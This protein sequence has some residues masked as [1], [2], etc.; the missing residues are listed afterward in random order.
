MIEQNIVC[1]A[2]DWFEDPTSNNHVM[3][4]LARDNQVLW[5][6]SIS[7]RTPDFKS[8]KDIAKIGRKLRSFVRGPTRVEE[9]LA[10]YTPVVLP[11]PHSSAAIALNQQILKTTIGVLRRR[12]GMDDFQLWTFL[13]TAVG[14]AGRL[15]ES[16]LVYYCTDEWSQFS[17]VDQARI[18]VMEAE[19]CRKADLVFTTSRA[20]L[21]RK[22]KLNAETH[23][24]AHGV[25]QAHFAAALDERTPIAP[26]IAG[27]QHP[28]LGFF[29]LI[30]DWIDVD[31]F[32]YLAQQRPDWSI[33]VIGE[34]KV[35]VSRLRRYPNIHLLG[36]K[37][38]VDL[39]R[40]CRAFDVGLC[41]FV[42][43]ELTRSVNPIKFRE[44]LSAGLPVVS[45]NIPEMAFHSDWCY[46]AE[47]APGFLAACERALIEDSPER[48][49]MRSDAMKG[50]TWE[51][52]V[53]ALGGHVKRVRERKRAHKRR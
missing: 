2:K 50:E 37:P 15:G 6:N 46:I 48:R 32:G 12:F 18:A 20:L 8:S 24:A 52:K 49:R 19:L 30:E 33:V 5:L 10:V 45:T 34:A 28:I 21:D 13:P 23:L 31:L 38:Y 36:R 44:Y 7:T 43:N 53:A 17:H 42:V 3:K 26:E 1:F 4:M 16:L 35:D 27:L 25:D 11:F 40:Y 41:P 47:D 14:Y 51:S 9:R 29:G 39:P 22:K